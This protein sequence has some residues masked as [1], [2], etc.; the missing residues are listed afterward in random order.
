MTQRPK[1]TT[2]RARVEQRERAIIDAATTLLAE[3]GAEKAT[4]SEIARRAGV[5]EGTVYLYFENKAALLRAVQASF[6]EEL[7]A[8]AVAGVAE[9]RGTKE[10]LE[11]L[12][13]L[14]L[15]T[16]IEDWPSVMVL[17]AG[18][19][20]NNDYSERNEQYQFNRAYVAIF[21]NVVREGVNRGEL[22]EDMPLSLLRDI[23][24]GTL[25]YVLRT[26]L[27]HDRRD[28]IEETVARMMEALLGGIA[29][30]SSQA[31]E[32][33]QQTA[34]DRTTKRLEEIATRLESTLPRGATS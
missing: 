9:I 4:M 28:A 27:L 31:S 22:R 12:A 11:F 10:R 30:P 29:Q 34:I 20:D 18:Y 1:P 6:Y 16:L 33:T 23:F 14:H 19:R 25:E 5:A 2:R 32:S 13:R 26:T 17:V 8:R 21:D 24:Y 7:T 3:T 15:K